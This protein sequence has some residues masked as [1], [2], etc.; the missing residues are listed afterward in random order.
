MGLN[1][2]DTTAW[3]LKLFLFWILFFLYVLG[4]FSPKY[5]HQFISYCAILSLTSQ[6]RH[7]HCNLFWGTCFSSL[8]VNTTGNIK[9]INYKFFRYPQTKLGDLKNKMVCILFHVHYLH[10]VL[11]QIKK[12]ISVVLVLSWIFFFVVVDNCIKT[13]LIVKM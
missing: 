10:L 6:G 11:S 5:H 9:C 4:F 12:I 7:F 13:Y 1:S 8:S 2:C 3:H